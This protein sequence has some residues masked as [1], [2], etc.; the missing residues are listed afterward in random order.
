MA[1]SYIAKALAVVSIP[2]II[3]GSSPIFAEADTAD[4]SPQY[5]YCAMLG[6]GAEKIAFLRDSG[7]SKE[8]AIAAAVDHKPIPQ[9]AKANFDYMSGFA[10][11][12]PKYAPASVGML[13]YGVCM[14][15]SVSLM[16]KSA[17]EY[18]TQSVE[19]CQLG[20]EKEADS[21]S[22]RDCIDGRIAQYIKSKIPQR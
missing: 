19:N 18:L 22:M 9:S 16:D 3:L 4:T 15:K 14:L 2:T 21:I 20:H 11:D 10:F 7:L 8:A 6:Q 12:F 1:R 13:A 5:K 17:T